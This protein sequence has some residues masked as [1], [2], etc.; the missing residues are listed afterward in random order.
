M[1]SFNLFSSSL[2]IRVIDEVACQSKNRPL[3]QRRLRAVP[4]AVALG[5][6]LLFVGCLK[7]E[8]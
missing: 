3:I 2:R 8:A 7:R 4:S 1:T 6:A 5:A